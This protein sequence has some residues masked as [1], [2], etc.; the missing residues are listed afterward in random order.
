MIVVLV[1]FGAGMAW[2]RS[3]AICFTGFCV[4]SLNE[5]EVAVGFWYSKI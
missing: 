1:E 5:R 4:S 3:V 2:L